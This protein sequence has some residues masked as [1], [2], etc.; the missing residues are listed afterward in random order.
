MTPFC[1]RCGVPVESPIG[2]NNKRDWLCVGCVER[3]EFER[4]AK[5]GPVR[6]GAILPGILADIE[7]AHAANKAKAPK[8]GVSRGK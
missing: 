3:L 7:K 8:Q 5:V 6:I 1:S 2:R 4:R